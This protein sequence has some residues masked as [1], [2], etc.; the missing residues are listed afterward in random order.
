LLEQI[1]ALD[2]RRLVHRLGTL[3]T[4]TLSAALV[5]LREMFED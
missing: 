3:D 1:R 5:R 2:K 4:K